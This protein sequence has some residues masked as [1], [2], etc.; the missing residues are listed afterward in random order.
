[1]ILSMTGYGKGIVESNN[2]TIEA[3]IKSLNSRYFELSIRLPKAIAY[4]E[5]EIREKIRKRIS[6]GKVFI[7]ITMNTDPSQIGKILVNKEGLKE[8]VTIIKEIKKQAK[9]KDKV[10]LE[11]ILSLKELFLKSE[12]NGSEEN[13]ENLE[14]ALF[15]AIDDFEKMKKQ[16]G[17]ELEKDLRK[18]LKLIE[19]AVTQVEKRNPEDIKAYFEKL[20]QKAK[21]LTA[22][23]LDNPDRL[24]MELALLSEKYDV[25]EECV[26]LRSHIKLFE[27]ALDNA[28]EPGRKLNFISQEINREANTINSKSV[29]SE[30]S[31]LG[32]L[33]KEELEKIR[34][35]IQNIE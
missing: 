24:N 32:I 15:L 13:F 6:R 25:T 27:D 12:E 33:I 3:E 28:A 10:T 30:I 31:H 5:F 2:Y 35:Q 9:L 22:D 16:E 1:M 29:T 34:E 4:K 23:L 26:R 14:K 8:T 21:D 19:D 18:R 7:S 17:K 20:K 11:R